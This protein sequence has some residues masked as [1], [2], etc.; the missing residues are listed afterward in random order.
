VRVWLALSFLAGWIMAAPALGDATGRILKVLP[1]HVDR[2]GRIALSPSL[3]ERDAY[4]ALLRKERALCDGL[5]F[6]VQWKTSGTTTNS[7]RLRLELLT[8]SSTKSKPVILE[9]PVQARSRWSR[10][11]HI[12]LRGEAYRTAGELIAW[13]ATLLAGDTLLAEQKSFLW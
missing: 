12:P 6:D 9:I 4:Q 8:T 3:F 10:W 11:S 13:R 2:Q 5:R 1:H 7:L